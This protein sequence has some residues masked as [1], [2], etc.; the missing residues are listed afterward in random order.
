M[1]GLPEVERAGNSLVGEWDPVG[2]EGAAEEGRD[3]PTP[4]VEDAEEV[5]V[6]LVV[7]RRE[8]EEAT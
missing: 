4:L 5:D 3:H 6:S 8:Y 1:F 2:F 7:T